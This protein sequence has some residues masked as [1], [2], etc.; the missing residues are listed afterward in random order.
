MKRDGLFPYTEF[1]FYSSYYLL[2]F[3]HLKMEDKKS[4]RGGGGLGSKTEDS[5]VDGSYL[6]ER[7]ERETPRSRWLAEKTVVH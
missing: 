3:E 4:E 6:P 1:G 2:D 5:L 7:R